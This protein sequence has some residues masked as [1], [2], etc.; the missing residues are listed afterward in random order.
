MKANMITNAREEASALI[1]ELFYGMN[2][3]PLKVIPVYIVMKLSLKKGIDHFYFT[4]NDIHRLFN[5]NVL[6]ASEVMAQIIDPMLSFLSMSE[7]EVNVTLLN[8]GEYGLD[9]GAGVN[10]FLFQFKEKE[11][12]D[13]LFYYRTLKHFNIGDGKENMYDIL[14]TQGV[15]EKEKEE[16]YQNGYAAE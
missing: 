3:L 5:C 9:E 16:Y 1:D 12:S 13:G 14:K 7:L 2:H 8:K 15:F 11:I 4:R 6:K 10:G